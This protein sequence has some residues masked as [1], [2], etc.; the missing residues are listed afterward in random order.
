MKKKI[1][2]TCAASCV[3]AEKELFEP[4]STLPASRAVCNLRTVICCNCCFA[5]ILMKSHPGSVPTIKEPTAKHT[6]TI[7][8]C[9]RACLVLFT[10]VCAASFACAHTCYMSNLSE[11]RTLSTRKSCHTP[12]NPNASSPLQNQVAEALKKPRLTGNGFWRFREAPDGLHGICM[13]CQ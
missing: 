6:L 1:C 9:I 5:A 13:M 7:T 2:F 12:G 3:R 10:V 11:K 4:A 8:L